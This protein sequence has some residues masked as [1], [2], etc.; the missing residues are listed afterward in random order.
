MSEPGEPLDVFR[1]ISGWSAVAFA[2]R[3]PTS[4]AFRFLV[5]GAAPANKFEFKLADPS[6]QPLP[7]AIRSMCPIASSTESVTR[8]P[9]TSP[10][11]AVPSRNIVSEMKSS[12][13]CQ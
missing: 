11:A 10:S 7:R 5:R 12:M 8:K 4:W 2:R 13:L 1:D 6:G 3:L 9:P